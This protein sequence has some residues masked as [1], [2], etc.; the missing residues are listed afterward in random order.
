METDDPGSSIESLLGGARSAHAL[1]KLIQ[2]LPEDFTRCYRVGSILGT[3]SQGV[4]LQ[5][6]HQQLD[7]TVVIKF[8]RLASPE[9]QRRFRLEAQILAQI[10]HHAI[11]PVYDFGMVAGE[12]YLVLEY[13]PGETLREWASRRKLDVSEVIDITLDVLEGLQELHS[14]GITHRDIKPDNLWITGGG[15]AKI[16]DLGIA[17]RDQGEGVTRTGAFVG[18]PAYA[19]PEQFLGENTDGRTDLYSLGVVLL[20]LI[21]GSNPFLAPAL[22]D[23]ANRHLAFRI[24]SVSASDM[25]VPSD[26]ENVILSMLQKSP[27]NRPPDP[28]AVIEVL[29]AKSSHVVAPS[30]TEVKTPAL[31]IAIERPMASLFQERTMPSGRTVATER[32]VPPRRPPPA[33]RRGRPVLRLL[34]MASFV[35]I[36]TVL[37]RLAPGERPTSTV[38]PPRE[39]VPALAPAERAGCL[40]QLEAVEKVPGVTATLTD[41]KFGYGVDLSSFGLVDPE[42][43]IRTLSS[44]ARVSAFV[45]EIGR[46]HALRELPLDEACL[47]LQLQGKRLLLWTRAILLF[48]HAGGAY[49]PDFPHPELASSFRKIPRRNNHQSLIFL[50]TFLEGIRMVSGRMAAGEGM[51]TRITELP[52]L[53]YEISRSTSAGSWE[54]GVD[55]DGRHESERFEAS[56]ARIPGEPPDVGILRQLMQLCWRRGRV[57]QIG[58]AAEAILLEMRAVLGELRTRGG[59]ETE[60]VRIWL[61]HE[62]ESKKG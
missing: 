58:P 42:T 19:A 18:T 60:A 37:L 34:A 22:P 53:V 29:R 11:V 28:A 24:D 9:S 17:R 59:A 62:L 4:V 16:L 10:R 48:Y 57:T 21:T 14:R 27:A 50:R 7:R 3:G 12:H 46:R 56:L 26:L 51:P 36:I 5:A 2:N 25:E 43:A 44:T 45:D 15:R 23:T 6:R 55:R 35:I 32:T 31:G 1:E 13:V 30:V 41:F 52:R 61:E 38:E 49:P 54:S 39:P 20:E 40:E 47:L 33:T 8:L